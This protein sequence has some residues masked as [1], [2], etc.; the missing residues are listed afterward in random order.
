MSATVTR[1]YQ[2]KKN[3]GLEIPWLFGVK[4]PKPRAIQAEC[5]IREY[6]KQMNKKQ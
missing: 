3:N 2:N 4:P 5:I 6:L 1:H